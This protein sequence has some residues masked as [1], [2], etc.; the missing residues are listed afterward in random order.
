VRKK[1]KET[2][3]TGYRPAAVVLTRKPAVVL[4]EKILFTPIVQKS[5]YDVNN[6]NTEKKGVMEKPTETWNVPK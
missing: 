2:N 4:K 6:E 1:A 5:R 3:N